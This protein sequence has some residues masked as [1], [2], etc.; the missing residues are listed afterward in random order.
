MSIG[1]QGRSDRPRQRAGQ[2]HLVMGRTVDLIAPGAI[3]YRVFADNIAICNE[4]ISQLSQCYGVRR[5]GFSRFYRFTSLGSLLVTIG[6]VYAIADSLLDIDPLV[7]RHAPVVLGD[8]LHH[9]EGLRNTVLGNPEFGEL[10]RVHKALPVL[11]GIS[12]TVY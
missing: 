4:S 6:L 11:V 10:A 1:H 2:L 9:L 5:C 7:L 8:H 3:G 12:I